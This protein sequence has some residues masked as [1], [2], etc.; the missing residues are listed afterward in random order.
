MTNGVA[1]PGQ[2]IIT[3]ARATIDLNNDAPNADRLEAAARLE[4]DIA[5]VGDC[6]AMVALN[7]RYKSKVPSLIENIAVASLVPQIRQTIAT[8]PVNKPSSP[9]AFA[10]GV[11]SFMLCKRVS[12][13]VNKPSRDEVFKTEW[14]KVFG[15]LS[16]RYLL[17][18]RRS[19]VIET[20]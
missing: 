2:D 6:T 19:A 9:L 8:M 11:S 7:D 12:P 3:L 16:E 18:L 15:T 5:S 4:R 10:S 1:D 20:K 17:R 13:E 14:D